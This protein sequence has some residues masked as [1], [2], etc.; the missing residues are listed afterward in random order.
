V[1]YWRELHSNFEAG[2]DQFMA[3]SQTFYTSDLTA[4]ATRVAEDGIPC[5]QTQC[6]TI[7]V[8]DSSHLFLSL[9]RS[10]S[11]VLLSLSLG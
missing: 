3:N 4:H 2:W 10:L 9:A 8:L 6:V 11:L 5:L 7:S 1:N